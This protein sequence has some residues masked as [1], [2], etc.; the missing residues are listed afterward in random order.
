V[1]KI[2]K[3][4]TAEDGPKWLMLLMYGCE[5]W[6]G[7]VQQDCDDGIVPEPHS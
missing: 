6:L 1:G 3:T 2:A 7:D 4:T 5:A